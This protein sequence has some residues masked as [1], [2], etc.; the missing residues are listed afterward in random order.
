VAAALIGREHDVAAVME[1]VQRPDVHLLTLT[2]PGGTGK[3]R[4]ALQVAAELL[5]AF[6]D[7]VFFVALAPIRD[8]ALVAS[9][10]AQVLGIKEIGGQPLT[11]RLTT[12]LRD[13]RLLLVIDSFEQ[14]LSSE[15]LLTAA[16]RRP[17][18]A[19]WGQHPRV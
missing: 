11:E 15:S 1:R 2:A 8:P 14:V 12:Y 6:A 4:L 3:T 17:H 13:K 5:G 7:G 16:G 10:I 19:E 18:T 9:T